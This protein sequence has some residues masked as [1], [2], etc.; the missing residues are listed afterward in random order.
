MGAE[1]AKGMA[2]PHQNDGNPYTEVLNRT[3]KYVA[4]TTLAEPLP[5]SGSSAAAS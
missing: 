5:S 3:R 2:R 1:M 4:S